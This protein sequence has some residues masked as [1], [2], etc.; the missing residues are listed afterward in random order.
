MADHAIAGLRQARRPSSFISPRGERDVN[1]SAMLITLAFTGYGQRPRG[2]EVPRPRRVLRIASHGPQ[3]PRNLRCQVILYNDA[4]KVQMMNHCLLDH[5]S[6]GTV[7]SSIPFAT[8]IIREA[9]F[10]WSSE[11]VIHSMAWIEESCEPGNEARCVSTV[12]IVLA[13]SAEVGSGVS[14]EP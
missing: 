1:G 5:A 10:A 8:L 9:R 11:C 3:G 7:C 4:S 12:F 14:S 6:C 13:S 2:R